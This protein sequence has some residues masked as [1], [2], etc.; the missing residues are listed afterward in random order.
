M[1]A[2]ILIEHKGVSFFENRLPNFISKILPV[3]DGTRET[4][5]SLNSYMVILPQFSVKLTSVK[6]FKKLPCFLLH[7]INKNSTISTL[8][9]PSQRLQEIKSS[10][11][12]QQPLAHSKSGKANQSPF[13][14]HKKTPIQSE[15]LSDPFNKFVTRKKD[16][17]ATP[18]KTP[19]K[20]KLSLST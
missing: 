2:I 15:N 1:A 12:K 4:T 9:I 3:I 8:S 17:E 7:K 18:S 6:S 16:K 19:S 11:F 20:Y 10:K 5:N 13:K 14:N